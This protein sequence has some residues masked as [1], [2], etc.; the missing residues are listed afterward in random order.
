MRKILLSFMTLA[1]ALFI[2]STVRAEEKVK[3]YMFEAGGCPACEAQLEYFKG[4]DSYNK[5][6]EVVREELYVDHVDWAKG[7]AYDLGVSVAEAFTKAGFKDV[8]ANATPLVVISD[9]Y[10]ANG[11]N[12]S[13]ESV[14]EEAY[15]KGDKEVVKCIESGEKNCL[16]ESENSSKQEDT[17]KDTIIIV[18]VFVVLIAGMA[19][20]VYVG[21]K[22]N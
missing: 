2:G 4:L 21:R 9:I 8:T 16:P 13:L 11:Y 6:F 18:L 20:L 3:V 15:E 14:I 12:Q 5:K 1:I 17:T 10:A 7:K 22:D 19:G